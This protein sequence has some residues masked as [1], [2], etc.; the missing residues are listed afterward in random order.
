MWPPQSVN[1]WPTPARA[2]TRAT[3]SPPLSSATRRAAH[4]RAELLQPAQ[5]VQETPLLGDLAARHAIDRDLGHGD[6]P[7]RRRQAGQ[8]A[9]LTAMRAGRRVARDHQVALGHHGLDG[10]VPV[11][12]RDL[13]PAYALAR[14]LAATPVGQVR[15]RREVTHEV[16]GV[17]LVDGGEVA[18]V[19]GV[20]QTGYDGARRDR[21]CLAPRPA[22]QLTAA[23]GACLCH[24]ARARRAERALV[25]AHEGLGAEPEPRAAFLARLPHLERH[26]VPSPGLPGRLPELLPLDRLALHAARHHRGADLLD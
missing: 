6:R 20:V 22:H 13:R 5:L 18:A 26:G 9:E 4:A 11:G 12:E 1:T 3:S 25:A 23:V 16:L 8:S 19:P 24:A 17:D 2:R 10:L 14:T 7:A 21:G 15:A